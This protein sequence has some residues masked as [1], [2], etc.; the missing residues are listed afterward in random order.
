MPSKFYVVQKDGVPAIWQSEPQQMPRLLKGKSGFTVVT[1]KP[2]E[3]RADA[4]TKLRQLFPG[5]RP[6]KSS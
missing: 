6:I 3:T 2:S 5:S 4:I 1:D